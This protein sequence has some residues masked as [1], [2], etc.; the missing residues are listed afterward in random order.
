MLTVCEHSK[1][2]TIKD[3]ARNGSRPP[4]PTLLFSQHRQLCS[5]DREEHGQTGS[6]GYPEGRQGSLFLLK[7]T[8]PEL[9][10]RTAHALSSRILLKRVLLPKRQATLGPA[11]PSPVLWA[12]AKQS[13]G[14]TVAL[15]P[16]RTGPFLVV[17]NCSPFRQCHLLSE[18][19]DQSLPQ[20]KLWQTGARQG[21]NTA[22]ASSRPPSAF[23]HLQT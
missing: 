21:G 13:I 23:L 3:G 19:P 14:T 4:T 12:A 18:A 7:A 9:M 16:H 1:P 5:L 15:R 8:L 6:Q 11:A 17:Y 22:S 10:V 20:A 2:W